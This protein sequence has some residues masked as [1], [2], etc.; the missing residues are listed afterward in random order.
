[1]F[2]ALRINAIVKNAKIH[3]GKV[4]FNSV[5]IEK[6]IH[7]LGLAKYVVR[8]YLR[9]PEVAAFSTR[10][11]IEDIPYITQ[12]ND[13]QKL[14]PD[15][16]LFASQ[17]YGIKHNSSEIIGLSVISWHAYQSVRLNEARMSCFT[18]NDL[19]SFWKTILQGLLSR[20][21]DFRILTNGGLADYEMALRLC[22]SMDLDKEHYLLE[23]PD[24]PS[25]LV[26]QLC[27]FKLV[28]GHRLHS[29]IVSTSLKIPVIPVV[30]SDKIRVFSEM[31]HNPYANWPSQQ[32]AEEIL[33]IIDKGDY[34][35]IEEVE[36]LKKKMVTFLK[37][38][39]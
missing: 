14:L 26:K 33:N 5:G 6:S 27:Q 39:I 22:E 28:I 23:L 1:M 2:Y 7:N 34:K 31:I 17:A 25:D 20:A 12:R 38:N 24:E 8:H 30:W 36:A 16:G 9:Q 35:Y 19:L 15:A 37:D 3:K 11:H 32:F 29:L 13:F 18:P 21:Q 10:D 4:L